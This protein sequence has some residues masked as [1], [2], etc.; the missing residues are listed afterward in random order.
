V[1]GACVVLGMVAGVVA[2]VVVGVVVGGGIMDRD[3]PCSVATKNEPPNPW[4]RASPGRT[5]P[6]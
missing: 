4:P 6:A 1:D 5:S 3:G 2:G